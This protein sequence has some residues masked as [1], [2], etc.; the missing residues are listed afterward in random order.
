MLLA[1]GGLFFAVYFSTLIITMFVKRRRIMSP[2]ERLGDDHDGWTGEQLQAPDISGMDLAENPFETYAA[3]REE[4]EAEQ[5][6]R[7][8]LTHEQRMQIRQQL[9]PAWPRLA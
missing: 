5:H 4:W 9:C 7:R 8:N 2:T 3:R 6:R 1:C